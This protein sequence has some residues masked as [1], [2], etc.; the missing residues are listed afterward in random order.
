MNPVGHPAARLPLL[1]LAWLYGGAIRIRNRYYDRPSA[2]RRAGVPVISVGNLTVGGTGKTPLVWWLAGRLLDE[3]HKP[4]IVSRGYGGRAGRGPLLVSRG[5]GPLCGPAEC[6]DEP[7]LLA[8]ILDGVSVIVGSNRT[9]GARAA[10]ASGH[11]VVILDD[12]FQHRRLAR[13]LD[14]VLVDAG[15]PL[16]EERLLP[17]GRLR[18]PLL[19]LA[20]ADVLLISGCR[21]GE[22]LDSVERLVRSHNLRAPILRTGYRRT[23]FFDAAGRRAERPGR[24]LAFCA[25]GNPARFR[26]DL[27]DEGIE[28]A[29]F[30]SWRDHHRYGRAELA[31]LRARAFE[32]NAVLITTEKDRVRLPP[33]E[34]EGTSVPLLTLRIEADPFDPQPLL[35]AVRGAVQGGRSH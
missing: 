12:G 16:G 24:A 17:A 35:A 11:D 1:A 6:G 25:I 13:D 28:I 22:T 21:R 20:R 2:S 15:E 32:L 3:G 29:D 30:E 9:A 27:E 31:R 7:Y 23:G 8:S 26:R 14:I 5:A 19:G 4:A 33:F 10:A 34:R 18:E